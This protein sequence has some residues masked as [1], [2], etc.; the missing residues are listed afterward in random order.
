MTIPTLPP[1]PGPDVGN[2]I[3]AAL[4]DAAEMRSQRA[5]NARAGRRARVARAANLAL[6][7]RYW[8]ALAEI[9]SGNV[10]VTAGGIPGALTL[11]ASLA[12]LTVNAVEDAIEWQEAVAEAWRTE[13]DA[14]SV[15]PYVTAKDRAN[16]YRGLLR[17]LRSARR[18]HEWLRPDDGN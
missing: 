7:D 10:S 17:I 4:A 12:S 16:R 13:V 11:G 14:A 2:V 1:E 6:A 18:W 9:E 15:I 5:R 3:S 8:E